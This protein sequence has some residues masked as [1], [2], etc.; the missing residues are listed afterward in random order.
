MF[1]K[2]SS[3]FLLSVTTMIG[4]AL[5]QDSPESYFAGTRNEAYVGW[6]RDTN[7]TK[8]KFL[9]NPG[10]ETEGIALHWTNYVIPEA[11]TT[12]VDLCLSTQDLVA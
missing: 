3:V 4:V 9:S 6:L 2:R 10:D 1:L 7:Y 8:S 5:S 12:Y 11:E